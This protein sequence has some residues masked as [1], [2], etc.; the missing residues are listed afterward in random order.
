MTRW[1]AG[2]MSSLSLTGGGAERTPGVWGG[3]RSYHP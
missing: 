1:L 3:G 2:I